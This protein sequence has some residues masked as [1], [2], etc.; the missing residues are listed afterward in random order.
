[1]RVGESGIITMASSWTQVYV[2]G[3]S[4]SINPTDDEIE[5]MLD[6]RFHLSSSSPSMSESIKDR[7]EEEVGTSCDGGWAGS[8][9]T[10]IKRDNEGKCRGFAFVSFH[11]FKSAS[12]FIERINNHNSRTNTME[13]HVHGDGD[14]DSDGDG[15]LLPLHLHAELSTP[16]KGTAKNNKK[17]DTH[18][19]DLRLRRQRKQPVRKHPVVISSDGKRTNLSKSNKSG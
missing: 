16:G 10:I 18:L 13:E 14:S 15:L 9:T 5:S 19:P 12:I 8:G 4:R 11:S 6:T 7:K 1:V 3:L 2:T 17:E